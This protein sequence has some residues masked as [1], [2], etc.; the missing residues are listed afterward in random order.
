MLPA[1][2]AA[3]LGSTQI[4]PGRFNV[5]GSMI[6]VYVL[7]T[8]VYGLQLVTSVQWLNDMFNGVALA[9]AVAF[10]VWRQK[11]AATR[12]RTGAGSGALESVDEAEAPAARLAESAATMSDPVTRPPDD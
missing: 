10:A 1:Y 5:W 3:F 7:Y 8:G 9:A 6:A 2:A 12:R 11:N 4:K